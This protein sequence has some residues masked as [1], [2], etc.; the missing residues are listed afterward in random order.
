MDV[1]EHVCLLHRKHINQVSFNG[2][3][4]AWVLNNP[5]EVKPSLFKKRVGV[6]IYNVNTSKRTSVY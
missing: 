6:S 2:E 4:S 3:H 1:C 5:C